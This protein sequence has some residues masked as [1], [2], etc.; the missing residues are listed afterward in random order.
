MFTKDL[1]VSLMAAQREAKNRRHEYLCVEHILYA[2]LH[3]ES[4][5]RI[6]KNCGGSVEKLK[7]YLEDFFTQQETIL[8]RGDNPQQT[9]AVQRVL[10]LAVMHVNSAGKT[11]ADVGDVLVAIHRESKSHASYYL[12]K[13]GITRLDLLNYISHGISK[14]PVDED[15]LES[16][17]DFTDEGEEV[18]SRPER[19]PL[20]LYT[21]N[22]SQ[23][24]VENKIDPLIGRE[25][26]LE[27][28]IQILCRRRKNNPIY[29]GE[30][31]V[32]KTAI[33]EGLAL[34]IYKESIPELLE[35][36][37]IFSLDIGALLAGTKFRGDFEQRVKAVLKALKK[38]PRSI[39]FIDEI[40][41]IVGAGATSG[42][43]M[44]VSNL[45]K[46]ALAK[47]T[48]R[49]IGSTTYEEYKKSFDKDHALSRR[50]QKIDIVEPT[51]EETI[52]ILKGLKAAYEN[53]HQ[54]R[55][56][57]GAIRTAAELSAKYINERFLPDKAIDVIDEV[58]SAVKLRPSSKKRKT[59]TALDVE[60]I[61]SRIAR[62]PIQRVTTS[63]KSQLLN[64]EKELKMRV[65]GQDQAITTLATSI[66]RSRAGLSQPDQ[67]VGSFLFTGPTGVGK[68][69][70]AKQLAA[71][72]GIHFER[73]DMSEYMEKHAVSR[74]IGAPPGYVGFDQGGLMTDAIRKHPHS[75]MLLD[76][77][78][79]AHPD[80]F[81]ILLQVM[82]H[83]KLTDNSGRQADFRNVV[84]IM[85]S[86]VGAKEMSAATIGFGNNSP[87]APGKQA[88]ERMFSPEFRNRLDAIINFNPLPEP[89][90]LLVVDKFIMALENKLQHKKVVINISD[91]TRKWL[92]EKG[93]DPK[94]GAR[95]MQRV[96]QQ[97]IETV[98]ADEVL[99]GQLTNGGQV[100]IDVKEETLT[101]DYS[102][103]E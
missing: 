92:G 83:A 101:F 4:G 81:N 66:K 69:E 31:G 48:L 63:D 14:V 52:K 102:E 7:E 98:L 97:E 18:E 95:L 53:H 43:S 42:G 89:V 94:F 26:E 86:N 35:G 22:L 61:V 32:G 29:V 84:I 11:T 41:T 82:D 75:V 39:L 19:D 96:I 79:K 67:P 25:F 99:F 44:D 91:E 5:I 9:L 3:N 36:S 16:N 2:L 49:C 10:H 1:E 54:L 90:I 65:F 28:T 34:M 20:A 88:L 8:A 58:G 23:L 70:V 51:V 74:L 100:F 87:T 15:D 56:T 24:A 46:P 13:E 76:E 27:R 59:V 62:I 68:T 45:L 47:G 6:V 38:K 73:F 37:E 21:L 64:L 12:Q 71:I 40:H 78:E 93:Y 55:Y 30:P 57:Q 85:T 60:Q 50:F 72:M 80:I 77:I 33:A 17:R 103:N